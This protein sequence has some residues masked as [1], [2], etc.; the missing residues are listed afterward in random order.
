MTATSLVVRTPAQAEG[1]VSLT[2]LNTD[3]NG[4]Q[5]PQAFTYRAPAPVVSSLSP[6]KG[7]ASGSTDVTINGSNFKAGVSVSVDT[8][9]ATIVSVTAT[10]IVVRMPAHAPALVGLTV[11]NP[12]SQ[13]ASKPSAYTYV[14]GGPAITQVLPGIGPD[15]RRQHDRDPRQRLRRTPRSSIGG[16]NATVLTRAADMLTVRVPA[17]GA[18]VVDVTVRNSDGLSVTAPDAYT[19]EDPERAVHAVLRRGRVGQLLP[20]ALRP[21]QPARRG[22]PGDGDLHRHAGHADDDGDD[23]AGAVAGDDRREQPSGARRARRSRPS[24]RRHACSVS[25]AR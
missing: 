24:S 18:G 5:L 13:L 14:S 6:V 20:D 2:V 11:T 19:Y 25:S 3:G 15:G 12:D 1:I 16:V 10:R 23:G 21:G 9:Q 22:R 7:P 4:V 17:H 8:L